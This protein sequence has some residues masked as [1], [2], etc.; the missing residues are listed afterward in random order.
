VANE[1]KTHEWRKHSLDSRDT[2]GFFCTT[3]YLQIDRSWSKKY[4]AK[5]NM[6]ALEN[7][8]YSPDLSPP[9]FSFFPRLK[10]VLKGQWLMS[11]EDVGANV[12]AAMTEILENCFQKYF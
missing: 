11:V 4:L 10:T 5:H 12:T 2:A 7:L 3:T 8:P 6:T 9:D 1:E